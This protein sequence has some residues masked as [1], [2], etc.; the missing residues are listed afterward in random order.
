MTFWGEDNTEDNMSYDS[1]ELELGS[2]P[3]VKRKINEDFEYDQS[4]VYKKSPVSIFDS[5]IKKRNLK[6]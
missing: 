5:K 4:D 1:H 3:Q 2:E 6:K